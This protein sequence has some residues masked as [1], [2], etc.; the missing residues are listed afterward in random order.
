MFRDGASEGHSGEAHGVEPQQGGMSGDW[1]V[2]QRN[3][4]SGS[5]KRRRH[6]LELISALKSH[7]MRV[8]MFSDRERMDE[9]LASAPHADRLR[10]IVGAGGDGTLGDLINRHPGK[11]LAI[12][13][14]GTENLMAKYLGIKCSAAQLS[15]IIRNGVT[16][17]IDVGQVNGRRFSIM[18]SAGFDAEV[19]HRTDA[20]RSGNISK[21][22][23]LQPIWQ[24]LRRYRHPQLRVYVDGE[25][26]PRLARMVVVANAPAY[27][28]GMIPATSADP[29]DGLLDVRLFERG[30]TFQ[31]IRYGAKIAM[32]SHERLP[33]VASVTAKSIRI[34]SDQPV[35]VQIDGDPAGFTP[36]EIS[37]VPRALELMV[38][39]DPTFV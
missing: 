25:E 18:L 27:A 35:P 30:S 14:L 12:L 1:V 34:E 6:L 17:T 28:L 29:S 4:T 8:R 2:I 21:L 23:Y 9:W 36:L 24:S 26:T 15:D 32:G 31:V 3:P 7:G 22:T 10:C 37:V 38:P 33:D 11:R 5:G 13:P 19:V 16:R 39:G 20:R